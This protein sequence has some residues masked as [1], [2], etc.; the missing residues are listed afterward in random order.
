MSK[1]PHHPAFD[2]LEA[3]GSGGLLRQVRGRHSGHDV[4]AADLMQE[5]EAKIAA[6]ELL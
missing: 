6:L 3:A 2:D 1:S 5:Y 4:Q